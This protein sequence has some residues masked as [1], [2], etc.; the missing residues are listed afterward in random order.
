MPKKTHKQDSR[1]KIKFGTDGWRAVIGDGFTF[2]NLKCISQA[3]AD[4]LNNSKRKP[5]DKK[6]KIAVGYD[7]RFMSEK[8]AEIVAC[9]FSANGI[10]VI[11]SD[12]AIPTPTISFTVKE[13]KLDLGIMITA[14][15][16]PPEFNGFKI[17]SSTGGSADINITQAV[18]KLLFKKEP[19]II[20]LN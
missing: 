20:S 3:T 2:E 1:E 8:F 11:L 17:K 14:S 12:R 9:V 13:R 7:T 4:F 18:E 16:N 6:L 5:K 15:H 10:K 19:K